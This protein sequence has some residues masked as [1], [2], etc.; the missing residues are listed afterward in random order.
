MK[1]NNDGFTL[2]ELLVV[3]A[4]IGILS[5]V[6][7]LS[8]STVRQADAKAAA[9]RTDAFLSRTCMGNMS[10]SAPAYMTLSYTDNHVVATYYENGAAVYS[11]KVGGSGV[12]FKYQLGSAAEKQ[13]ADGSQLSLSF[14]RETG[15]LDQVNGAA[16]AAN[17]IITCTGSGRTY[18]ITINH[19]TGSHTV[20]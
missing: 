16:A 17:L 14:A 20:S 15:A 1:K 4:I 11:E 5:A 13:I 9:N 19:V 2:I 8:L 7:G 12:T 3:I 6:V 18:T 10:R